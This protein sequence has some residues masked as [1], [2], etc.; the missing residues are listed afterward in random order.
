[1]TEMVEKEPSDPWERLPQETHKAWHAFVAYR[2]LEGRARS[3]R[4]A[5][6]AHTGRQDAKDNPSSWDQWAKRNRW[7][8]RCAAWDAHQDEIRRE[9]R[10]NAI[11]A[12][13]NQHAQLAEQMLAVVR[14]E[15]SKLGRRVQ[16]QLQRLQ[17][18]PQDTVAL[19]PVVAT[20]LLADMAA[21]AT[22]IERQARG[23]A[24]TLLGIGGNAAGMTYGELILKSVK[25]GS[26]GET[27]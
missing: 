8:E 20:K 2:T 14:A 4:K 10:E 25:A 23:E 15:I 24:D 21:T 1:M 27:P 18:N 6:R 16:D 11:R 3:I 13:E 19:R 9:A 7:V 26:G 5:Y 22:R 12:M 17:A